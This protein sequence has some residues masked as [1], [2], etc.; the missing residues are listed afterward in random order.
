MFKKFVAND[1]IVEEVQ[2]ILDEG[3]YFS[4]SGEEEENHQAYCRFGFWYK[5]P[6]LKHFPYDLVMELTHKQKEKLAGQLEALGGKLCQYFLQTEKSPATDYDVEN[7]Q[8]ISKNIEG[9]T[10]WS[11]AFNA[12]Q[13]TI[14]NLPLQ[15]NGELL[16]T[17][18]SIKIKGL[19]GIGVVSWFLGE[20]DLHCDNF[21]LVD[22][23]NKLRV[24]KFDHDRMFVHIFKQIAFDDVYYLFDPSLDYSYIGYSL[25]EFPEE[26][27][28]DKEHINKAYKM[29][30]Q[31]TQSPIEEIEEIINATISDEF[32]AER[33]RL[34]EAISDRQLSLME[35]SQ[36]DVNYLTYIYST[37]L[38]NKN[39]VHLS[40]DYLGYTPLQEAIETENTI[41]ILSLLRAGVKID[42]KCYP[43]GKE[44]YRGKEI[45]EVLLEYSH[46]HSSDDKISMEITQLLQDQY[47]LAEDPE[48]SAKRIKVG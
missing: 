31:I 28:Q 2:G 45:K 36:E 38:L 17:N 48:Q 12:E 1:P 13:K 6:N 3:D 14:N 40:G 41:L 32:E 7:N 10:L 33:L 11:K 42:G 25:M 16:K 22:K 44:I 30:H 15:K 4:A 24:Y 34:I 29:I 23:G 26:I 47:G 18:M 5:T 46:G 21:G 35:Q 20:D 39:A 19:S 8:V 37:E 43:L 27:K 9:L